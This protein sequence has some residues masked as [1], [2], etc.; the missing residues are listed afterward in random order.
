MERE[1]GVTV[2]ES[3]PHLKLMHQAKVFAELRNE[4]FKMLGKMLGVVK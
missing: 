3:Y 1:G 2:T 4:E